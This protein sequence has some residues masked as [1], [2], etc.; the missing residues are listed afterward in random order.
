M[1]DALTESLCRLLCRHRL[2]NADMS[3]EI[4][5]LTVENEA[6]RDRI[7]ALEDEL[8]QLRAALGILSDTD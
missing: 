5:R 6:Q 4:D 2:F 8:R 1:R 7:T 3:R